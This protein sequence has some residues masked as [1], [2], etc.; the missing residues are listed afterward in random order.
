MTR[1]AFTLVELLGVIAI[2]AILAAI[3]FPVFARARA[4]AQAHSCRMNLLNIG[5]ALRLYAAD[6][7]SWYPPKEDDLSPL[8]DIHLPDEGVFHC[9]SDRSDNIPMGAPADKS[10]LKKA[11]PPPMPPIPP[12]G[13]PPGPP[14]PPPGTPPAPPPPEE[15][16]EEGVIYTTYYYRAGRRHNELPRA[17]LVSDHKACHGDRA[18]VLFSDGAIETL[19]E[20]AWEELGFRP[21]EEILPGPL[22][23]PGMPGAPPGMPLPPGMGPPMGPPPPPPPPGG[24]R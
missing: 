7:D 2:I 20:D 18:N 4:Q 10:L 13:M 11:A 24:T 3:L 5:L 14:G 9:P 17:P 8:L 6:H 1:R 22:F 21:I 16:S 12:P 23:G 19:T 15:E